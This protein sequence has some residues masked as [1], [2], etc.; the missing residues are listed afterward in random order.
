[1]WFIPLAITLL[2]IS[3][4]L[5]GVR[6]SSKY[7]IEGKDEFVNLVD[8]NLGCKRVAWLTEAAKQQR[9]CCKLISSLSDV[10]LLLSFDQF[11]SYFFENW[12]TLIHLTNTLTAAIDFLLFQSRSKGEKVTF[13]RV[14]WGGGGMMRGWNDEGVEEG[15]GGR[16][17]HFIILY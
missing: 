1:M 6:T 9:T 8:C 3:R 7:S 11:L 16:S 17:H 10:Y 14:E 12:G 2:A 4:L 15:G 13:A 5:S